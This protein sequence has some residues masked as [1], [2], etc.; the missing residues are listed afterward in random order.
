[1]LTPLARGAVQAGYTLSC[2]AGPLE[3]MHKCRPIP[4]V[5]VM[6]ISKEQRS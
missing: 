6:G 2:S 5:N 3:I 4:W 1:M